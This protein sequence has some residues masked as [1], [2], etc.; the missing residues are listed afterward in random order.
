MSM[1]KA[2]AWTW[3][4]AE[5]R[6][7]FSLVRHPTVEMESGNQS[8]YVEMPP[9][10]CRALL[11]RLSLDRASSDQFRAMYEEYGILQDPFTSSPSD[12]YAL[13]VGMQ[14]NSPPRTGKRSHHPGTETSLTP[15]LSTC[16]RLQ[17]KSKRQCRAAF[18]NMHIQELI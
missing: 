2:A 9:L 11:H 14:T 15:L 7:A 17:Q 18:K 5:Q 4:R 12:Q 13:D 1:P 10:L 6:G 16:P 3:Q 8:F